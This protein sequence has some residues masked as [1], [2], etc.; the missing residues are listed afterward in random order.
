M[1]TFE[2]FLTAALILAAVLIVG[3]ICRAEEEV[4]HSTTPL[5]EIKKLVDDD[6]AWLV[7]CREVEEWDGGHIKDAHFLPLSRLKDM[8]E[9]PA[10]LPKD[11]PI[12]IHCMVGGRALEAAKILKKMGYDPRPI[13][14][15][16][17]QLINDG[18]FKEA[19]KTK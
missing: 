2:L 7:D 17:T 4:T 11:K 3:R 18:G 16:P 10:E 1:K 14:A 5:K 15:N 6:K 19:L 12:Y 8:K 13:K 9:A